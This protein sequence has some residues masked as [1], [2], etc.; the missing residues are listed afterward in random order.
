MIEA[1]G[2][3]LIQVGAGN[4]ENVG[5]IVK[6]GGVKLALGWLG[7]HTASVVACRAAARV[8]LLLAADDD[9]VSQLVED[10]QAVRVLLAVVEAHA[11]GDEQSLGSNSAM[12]S[13][14][15]VF[16][17]A[18]DVL[19]KTIGVLSV[20]ARGSSKAR[21]EICAQHGI[22]VV[23]GVLRTS[24]SAQLYAAS[25]SG[26]LSTLVDVIEGEDADSSA[27][28]SKRLDDMVKAKVHVAIIGAFK[29]R[30]SDLTMGS[31]AGIILRMVKSSSANAA[32]VTDSVFGDGETDDHQLGVLIN[33][34]RSC[35]DRKIESV[36]VALLVFMLGFLAGKDREKK[37]RVITEGALAAMVGLM[38][39]HKKQRTIQEACLITLNMLTSGLPED[40]LADIPQFLG[41]SAEQVEQEEGDE[42]RSYMVMRRAQLREDFDIS[43]ASV[44]VL[45]IGQVVEAAEQRI[46]HLGQTRIKTEKGW[47]SLEAR[48]GGTLLVKVEDVHMGSKLQ[49]KAEEVVKQLF[50][51]LT[52]FADDETVVEACMYAAKTLCPGSGM[53]KV[54]MANAG[55]LSVIAEALSEHAD[56]V[57]VAVNGCEMLTGVVANS[58]PIQKA[59]KKDDL[60]AASI[61]KVLEIHSDSEVG[62]TML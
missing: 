61:A 47:T 6:E 28:I 59:I 8:L 20:M 30:V 2:L 19:E 16:T 54:A 24:S 26:V 58:K 25:I 40:L 3:A 15:P 57:G 52:T 44:G 55:Q 62:L 17:D 43:S 45:E 1:A 18:V 9:G 22:G 48:D 5:A 34:L 46:N 50:A 27:T 37:E 7:K 51:P 11:D 4:G 23:S 38:S 13:S 21:A 35:T 10:P 60:L 32:V 36:A 29:H 14:N 41:I 12:V 49:A 53:L 33:A 56:V 31:A 39:S 42:Q